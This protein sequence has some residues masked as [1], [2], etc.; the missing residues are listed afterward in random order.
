MFRLTGHEALLRTF[1]PLAAF[2]SVG[3]AVSGGPDS[4]ALMILAHEWAQ[5]RAGAP[6]LIV[7]SVDHGLRVEAGAEV[8]FVLREAK[9]LGLA[10]RT[11]RWDG[12]KPQTG[13]QEAARDA[14]YQ[15]IAAA[16]RQ[17][18]VGILVTAHHGD[19]QAETVLMRLAHGSGLEGLAGMET[20]S[21]LAGIGVFRPLL[22]T[23]GHQLHAIV[24]LAGLTPMQ[25]P[26]NAD[27]HYER[28]RWRQ[29]MPGLAA[30]GLD[31]TTLLQFS[32][33]ARAADAA[34]SEWADRSYA[35][36]VAIDAFGALL[37]D[38]ESL[39][40]LPRAVAVKLLSR[41]L[42]VAGGRQRPRALGTVERLHAMLGGKAAFRG[43]TALGCRLRLRGPSLLITRETGRAL[44]AALQI[45]PE[46]S[47][48]WDRRFAIVNRSRRYAVGVRMAQGLSR[49]A[50][51]GLLGR[52]LDVP[53]D[54]I[55]A[56][57]LV[58][59]A[60]GTVLALGG[61]GLTDDVSVVIIGAAAG[62]HP[63][64]TAN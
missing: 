8:M 31:T 21:Q 24:S 52:K 1:E 55:R 20:F 62:A 56:A 63:N 23:G 39:A 64:V 11:L 53:A 2:R 41:L 13:V 29:A 28:V 5:R 16:M 48:V 36:L 60:D 34:V 4:L 33:R 27:T 43:A 59:G 14:R 45:Q 7:Y 40:R 46:N 57:P 12:P 42:A 26:G 15:L 25:D 61:Y 44:P 18:G 6:M 32:A 22:K 19:D 58:T 37:L 50:A 38:A 47:L 3:L 10:A 9:K 30:L 35:G 17:D 54:A 51:E 49:R